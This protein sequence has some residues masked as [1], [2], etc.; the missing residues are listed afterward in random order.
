M[1]KT[2]L[3]STGT[4]LLHSNCNIIEE[5]KPFVSQNGKYLLRYVRLK[6]G[7]V[8]LN[9]VMFLDKNKHLGDLII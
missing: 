1:Q 8:F 2:K 7:R 9:R 5:S 3:K 4:A 6:D